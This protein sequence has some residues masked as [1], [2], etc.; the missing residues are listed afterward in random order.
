MCIYI[1][2]VYRRKL[3]PSIEE[4]RICIHGLR[5][6]EHSSL[7]L[8]WKIWVCGRSH[9]SSSKGCQRYLFPSWHV[10]QT[11]SGSDSVGP[12]SIFLE[13]LEPQGLARQSLSVRV[14]IPSQILSEM[15]L[16]TLMG[17]RRSAE[18]IDRGGTKACSPTYENI[19]MLMSSKLL[20]QLLQ[21]NSF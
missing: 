17:A 13:V 3:D 7:K 6:K 4:E 15:L 21:M 5:L 8:C 20:C 14:S 11:E 10:L 1:Y 2:G 9:V 12:G 16:K 18:A 19:R